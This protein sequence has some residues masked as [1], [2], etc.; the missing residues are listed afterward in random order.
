MRELDERI[1][2]HG[3]VGCLTG[4]P[5]PGT[6]T[7]R[8]RRAARERVRAA[9]GV[10]GPAGAGSSA[11]ARA[12]HRWAAHGAR[13]RALTE[14]VARHPA[15]RSRRA[16]ASGVSAAGVSV[17]GVP[18]PGV[19]APGVP[20]SGPTAPGPTAHGP[21]AHGRAARTAAPVGPAVPRGVTG[22]P[23]VAVRTPRC[24]T[25]AP[26][27]TAT[28][29]RPARVAAPSGPRSVAVPAPRTVRPLDRRCL[30]PARPRPARS[31]VRGRLE[32]FLTGVAVLLCATTAVV[33][34]GLLGDAAAGW[35][36]P[37]AAV[38]SVGAVR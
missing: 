34:L 21:T 11:V 23:N 6:P 25:S 2:D 7:S 37:A 15:A 18:V 8:A 29:V 30:V 35:N 12:A 33:A 13:E 22:G 14:S 27:S 20:T 3:A 28:L 36:A 1:R 38:P 31:R 4:A 24:T 32:R 17:P 19:S 5:A 10:A 16:T 9:E 26:G